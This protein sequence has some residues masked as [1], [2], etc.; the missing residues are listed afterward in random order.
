MES[1][2][3]DPMQ[4][5]GGD[6]AQTQQMNWLV[7]SAIVLAM[8]AIIFLVL[9]V[10]SKCLLPIAAILLTGSI[11]A[12]LGLVTMSLTQVYTMI[13]NNVT[14]PVQVFQATCSTMPLEG[15]ELV[16]VITSACAL[17]IGIGC[18]LCIFS[19]VKQGQY[20][21][22]DHAGGLSGVGAMATFCVVGV[23]FAMIGIA[24]ASAV[25]VIRCAPPGNATQMNNGTWY[26]WNQNT[27][28]WSRF[29]SW[30]HQHYGSSN[31]PRVSSPTS[32]VRRGTMRPSRR[33]SAARTSRNTAVPRISPPPPLPPPSQDPMSLAPQGPTAPF[34][35][36][37]MFETSRFHSDNE[38]HFRAIPPPQD[39]AAFAS[40]P[41]ITKRIFTGN[42]TMSKVVRIK[43]S[44]G[45]TVTVT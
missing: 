13:G 34:A 25:I 26:E 40:V 45:T 10:T 31:M 16:L 30:D 1:N 39:Q 32:I 8:C 12:V 37:P 19:G 38:I 44:N 20:I 21:W 9:K 15:G 28:P 17:S 29:Y 22:A 42:A 2:D 7:S 3:M 14:N 6:Q 33:P 4:G 36:T 41:R 35:E 11:V 23:P 24:V 18:M 43:L 27:P 5:G